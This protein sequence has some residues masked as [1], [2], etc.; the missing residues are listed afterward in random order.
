MINLL[1]LIKRKFNKKKNSSQNFLGKT[2]SKV[3]QKPFKIKF[4]L[5][6]G[7]KKKIFDNSH[8]SEAIRSL[9]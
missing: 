4:L 1:S 6:C 7:I 9:D 3:Y 5:S 2:L 8:C